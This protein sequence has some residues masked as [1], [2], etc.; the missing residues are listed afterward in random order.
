M[1]WLSAMWRALTTKQRYDP[2]P[3]L[4]SSHEKARDPDLDVTR[5][6]QHEII[7]RFTGPEL[8]QQL[9]ERRREQQQRRERWVQTVEEIWQR[10]ANV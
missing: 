1:G 2:P 3:P 9:E 8:R 7:N 10:N 6:R 5:H 4:T